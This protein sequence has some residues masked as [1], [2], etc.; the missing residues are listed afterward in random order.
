MWSVGVHFGAEKK[1]NLELAILVCLV[2][3][4]HCIFSTTLPGTRDLQEELRLVCTSIFG[5]RPVVVECSANTT[6]EEF[7]EGVLV[8]PSNRNHDDT[9]MR[10]DMDNRA[11]LAVAELTIE[12]ARTGS[13]E[14][15]RQAVL[16]DP[17]ASSSLTPEQ[18]WALCDELTAAHGDL[19]QPDLR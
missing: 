10:E 13:K 3:R 6:V 1:Q 17:N 16:A 4:Q 12:A 9:T 18:I 5:L 2:A 7:S 19:I 15:V 8:K 14:R 11:S